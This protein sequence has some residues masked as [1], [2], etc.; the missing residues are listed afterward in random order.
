MSDPKSLIDSVRAER[1]KYGTPLMNPQMGELLNA[2]AWKHRAAE[3]VLAEKRTGAH[4]FQPHT[5]IPISRDVLMHVPSRRMFD[6]LRDVGGA[7]E[8]NWIDVGQI[9]M[10]AVHPVDPGNEEPEEPEDP[11]DVRLSDD[12]IRHILQRIPAL[13]R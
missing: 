11:S 5:G 9:D 1:A 13:L 2:V 4:S 8:P 3:W 12:A 7:G 6:V 10:P